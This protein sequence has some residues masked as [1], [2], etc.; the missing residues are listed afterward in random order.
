MTDMKNIDQELVQ[1]LKKVFPDESTE[2]ITFFGQTIEFLNVLDPNAEEFTFQ[3][4]DDTS[5]KC[6]RLAKTL[7]GTLAQHISELWQ[8]NKEGAGIFVNVNETNLNGRCKKDIRSV[9]A[10]FTDHDVYEKETLARLQE[11][12]YPPSIITESSD[13]KFHAY[14]LVTNCSLNDFSQYQSI[15]AEA[16]DSDK[17]VKDISRVMRLPGFL[18]NKKQPQK[19]HLR[20]SD[21]SRMYEASVLCKEFSQMISNDKNHGTNPLIDNKLSPISSKYALAAI[22]NAICRIHTATEGDRNNTLNRETY[23]LAQ[24]VASGEISSNDGNNLP[25]ALEHAALS[26]G[27]DSN[28]I[29]ATINSAWKSG[30]CD[31][32]V[33]ETILSKQAINDD[34]FK[35]ALRSVDIS[36]F[37][38]SERE[39][40]QFAIQQILPRRH[41]TL[42]SGNGGVGKSSIGLTMAAHVA[43]GAPFYNLPSNS[44]NALF[45]SLEDEGDICV[46]RL[47]NIV[48]AYELDIVNIE[49]NLTIIDGTGSRSVLLEEQSKYGDGPKFTTTFDELRSKCL[50]IQPS[51]VVIDN[52]SNGFGANEN[53]RKDVVCF[54][55][56]LAELA[57]KYNTAVLILAHVDKGAVKQGGAGNNYSGSTAWNNSVRSRL[58]LVKDGENNNIKLL[59]E[60]ANYSSLI[61]DRIFEFG[62]HGIP[63]PRRKMSELEILKYTTEARNVILEAV[64]QANKRGINIG[65]STRPGNG[66]AMH[67]LQEI[68]VFSEY[69]GNT[70][71]E[72]YRA[73]STIINLIDSGE[74]ILDEYRNSASKLKKRLKVRK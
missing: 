9:R 69:F 67:C 16:L 8:L 61:N 1:E 70:K 15:M 64:E 13:G 53:I 48:K 27:L 12:R 21:K 56:G 18:H 17:S 34:D 59:H 33:P 42:F 29:Q 72:K 30:L 71:K 38:T 62:G 39:G 51:L 57:K 43:C 63:V 58:A 28:E 73:R 4:F 31:P 47:K 68:K 7:H 55:T 40:V 6:K 52:C 11:L 26:I 19:V 3:T 54:I 45:I 49:K 10:L 22:N 37:M 24:L 25:P 36:G 74:L 66:S 23:G 35:P 41:V 44:G 60:K 20:F 14:W 65:S 2:E 46:E 32:K 50:E 5:G